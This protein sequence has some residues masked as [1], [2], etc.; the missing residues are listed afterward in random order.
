MLNDLS[1]FRRLI[2]Y[3]MPAFLLLLPLIALYGGLQPWPP[4]EQTLHAYPGQTPIMV[5]FS[6]KASYS[7]TDDEKRISR[8]YILLPMIFS[9]PKVITVLKINDEPPV[10]SESVYGLIFYAV[11]FIACLA[12]TW[13]FWFRSE[14]PNAT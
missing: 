12:G 11:W 6:Y 2:Q 8:S 3:G 13:W 5:G 4:A 9:Q 1:L 14:K 10:V 7:S